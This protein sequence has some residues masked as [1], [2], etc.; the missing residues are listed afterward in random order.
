MMNMNEAP[1]AADQA[2]TEDLPAWKVWFSTSAAVLL[3]VTFIVAGV[4]K[5]SDPFAAAVRMA[6]ARVPQMLSLPAALAFGISET[7]AG[8]LLLVPR[9]RRWGAWLTGLLLVAFII[10]IALFY[11]VLRGEECN[12]FPWVQRAVGPAF[13]IGDVVMLLMAAA[14]GWWA[15][16]SHG[17]RN[18]F[19]VLG[20][21]CVFAGVSFGVIMTRRT[22]VRAPDFVTVNG[23]P[24]AL[25]Q[26]RVFLFF[27]N[28]ECLH[29]DA[30]ARGLAKLNWGQ[31]ANVGV[32]T[33]LP[34]FGPEFPKSTH[35][36]GGVTSDTELLRK[37]FSFVDVPYGVALENGYQRAVFTSFDEQEPAATL[38]KLGFVN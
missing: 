17:L 37:T 13:F 7:F 36:G 3:A 29:C 30:A 25:N 2:G 19:I 16:P 15:R 34:Q 22:G 26:G 28:P 4:W 33:Q 8:V 24:F 18:A 11:N 32:V 38:R 12:C 9:F 10:Y 6:Q 27:F 5:I 21:V 23:K 20:A 35:L 1:A 14:A 31:T